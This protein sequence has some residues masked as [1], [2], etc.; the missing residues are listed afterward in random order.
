MKKK[1]RRGFTLVE[2]MI[3]VAIIGLLA[4]IAVPNFITAR[5]AA[6]ESRCLKQLQNLDAAIIN[7]FADQNVAATGFADLVPYFQSAA[8]VPQVCPQDGT[9]AYQWNGGDPLCP[10]HGNN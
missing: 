10:T 9:T 1:G 8:G 7:Y 2:I 6:A 4:A 5:D 3:V